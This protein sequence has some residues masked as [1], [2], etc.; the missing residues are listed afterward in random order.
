MSPIG[1][2][3]PKSR[4][5]SAQAVDRGRDSRC[6]RGATAVTLS[7]R[8]DSILREYGDSLVL[9]V[10]RRMMAIGGYDRA[11]ALSAQAFVALIPML[12]VV[13]ALVPVAL[14]RPYGQALLAGSGMSDRA[15]ESVSALFDHPREAG[16]VTVVGIGLLVVTVLGFIR[17]LQRAYLAAWELPTQGLR[18]LGHGVLA[19]MALI[20]EFVLLALFGPVLA[21]VVDS[22]L[23]RLTVQALCATALWWPVQYLLLGGRIGWR[24]LLPGAALTGGGQAGAILVSG[25]YLPI[26][27]NHEAERYGVVGVAIALLSWLV[28]FGLLIVISAVLSAELARTPGPAQIRDHVGGSPVADEEIGA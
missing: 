14:Q 16:S 10:P 1:D 22:P 7:D 13:A 21:V 27:I 20:S 25:L 24:V 15:A 26:A 5:P 6:E 3:R 2:T 11:L 4:T 28:V 23:I 8:R 9:R 18:G 19:S 17:A 12:I